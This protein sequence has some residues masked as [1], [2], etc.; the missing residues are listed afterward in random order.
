MSILASYLPFAQQEIAR[1]AQ[2]LQASA[3][4]LNKLHHIKDPKG[5][6]PR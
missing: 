1:G 4:D 6:G 3:E 5:H 2:L